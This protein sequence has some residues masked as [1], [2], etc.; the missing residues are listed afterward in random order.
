MIMWLGT[1][2]SPPAWKDVYCLRLKGKGTI[3]SRSNATKVLRHGRALRALK[4][5][6]GVKGDGAPSLLTCFARQLACYVNKIADMRQ[7]IMFVYFCRCM[8]Y[9]LGGDSRGVVHFWS[10]V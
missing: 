5:S 2:V 10:A 6:C 4:R 3:L 9:S 7:L 8:A 1:P